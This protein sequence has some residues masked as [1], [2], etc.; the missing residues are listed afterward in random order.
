MAWFDL[1]AKGI[2][3]HGDARQPVRIDAATGRIDLPRNSLP[4]YR[5]GFFFPPVAGGDDAGRATVVLAARAN[6][7]PG[8]R[9]WAL[10]PRCYLTT[11]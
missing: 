10:L 7:R 5:H 2:S 8:Q 9:A 11:H 4:P 3:V 1:D 6:A